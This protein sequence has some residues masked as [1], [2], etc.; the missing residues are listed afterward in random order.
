MAEPYDVAILG[1]TP[2]GWAAA[3][4][5]AARKCRT[6]LVQ[7]DN[8]D[9]RCNLCDW[10]GQDFFGPKLLGKAL[11][12]KAGAK[13]F[14]EV[15]YHSADLTRQVRSRSRTRAGWFLRTDS[16][17]SALREAARA[18][19]AKLWSPRTEPTIHLEENSVRLAAGRTTLARVLLIACKHPNEI[20]SVLSLPMRAAAGGSLV[21]AALDVPLRGPKRRRDD[22]ALHVVE[23]AE[24]TQLGMFLTHD[25]TLHLRM[26]CH[27]P[28]TDPAAALS[29][30]I[31]RLRNAELLGEPLDIDRAT[32]SVWR[33]PAG[34]ALELES[35][36]AKR[37]LLMGTAGGFADA[38]TGQTLPACV[39]SALLAASTVLK[40]LG[41][42]DCQSAL[43]HFKDSWRPSLANYIRPPNTSLQL[44]LPLLFTNQR[45]TARFTAALLN[46]KNI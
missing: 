23:S 31:T 8:D 34:V 26:I 21:V 1:A 9:A 38:T 25:R 20:A 14:R 6:V 4:E 24:K 17:T 27:S 46:G 41:S 13:E 32:G 35:H 28:G 33:P 18:A 10:V 43:M 39:R 30:M 3:R 11:A 44:L 2:A 29:Q 7:T 12:V 37:C 5:L 36:V 45:I 16:L 15:C 19:G 40:A 22:S 42:D